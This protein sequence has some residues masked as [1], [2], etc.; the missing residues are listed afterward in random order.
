MLT[1]Y[2]A[3]GASSRLRALQYLP[4][5]LSAGFLVTVQYL[6]PSEDLQARYLSGQYS[7][8]KLL[9]N[10][11]KRCQALLKRS[12][13]DVIWI[14]KEALPWC[15]LW[16]E[17]A[18]LRN[19]PYVLDFDDAIFHNYDQHRMA[20]VRR[21]FGGRLDG[22]MASATLV[23]CG[24]P[25]LAERARDAGAKRVTQLPT[26]IDLQR[27][28]NSS[29]KLI[30]PLKPRDVARIVWIG[31]PS[32]VHYLQM[33]A[34]PLQALAKQHKFVFRVIGGG[35]IDLPGVLL[36]HLPWSEYTEVAHISDCDV[37]VMPLVDSPFEWGKCG[38]KLIQYMACSLPVVASPIGVNMQIVQPG[39]NGFLANTPAQWQD[40][41]G[42]LLQD[43]ALSSK[44]GFAGRLEV[45]QTYCIQHTGP[46]MAA[47]L[48]SAAKEGLVCAA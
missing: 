8:L 17:R 4:G 34:E 44:M 39:V 37:G 31:T 9:Q 20:W 24:S 47:I 5:L 14:E 32:T 36:E 6:L 10:Y 40:A 26:A 11:T 18:L 23:V 28:P 7:V 43:R 2:G 35:P 27:Y 45:E 19:V 12:Q 15:P 46:K 29:A 16:L 38:Y 13:F 33:L 41:L 30:L 22:L 3:L 21:V 1:R 25:Y 48:R 42:Q